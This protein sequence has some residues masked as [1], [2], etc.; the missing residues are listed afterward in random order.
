[1]KGLLESEI[2]K[3][4]AIDDKI[5]FVNVGTVEGDVIKYGEELI[6]YFK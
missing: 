6:K 1:M 5:K 4:K 3:F 2:A